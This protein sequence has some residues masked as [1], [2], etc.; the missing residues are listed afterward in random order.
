MLS[1]I[2]DGIAASSAGATAMHDVTEGGIYGAVH[3]L[4]TASKTGCDLY[5]D[6]IP[7]MDVTKKICS[8]FG[9]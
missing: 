9:I 4:C 2:K 7:V 5:S 1:V 3:E 8:V 6:D